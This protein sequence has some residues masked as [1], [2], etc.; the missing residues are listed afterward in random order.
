MRSLYAIAFMAGIAAFT[1]AQ[2]ADAAYDKATEDRFVAA[3]A[4]QDGAPERQAF[5]QC[6]W[7]EFASRVDFEDFKRMDE[8]ARADRVRA[9]SQQQMQA[10]MKACS[11][12]NSG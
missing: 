5:C 6:V 11:G 8:Q 2:N 12:R 10:A 1:W 9:A 3:C 4:N 7:D